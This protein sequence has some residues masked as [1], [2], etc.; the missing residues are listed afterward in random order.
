MF[1]PLTTNDAFWHHQIL[2]ACYQLVQSVL[3][4]SS[5]LAER[6]GQVEVGGSTI[7]VDSAWWQLQLSI[8]KLWSM[9]GGPFVC[10]LA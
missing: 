4:I 2:A 9:T 6:V 8:G 3:K 1:N 7:L 10:F 5:V